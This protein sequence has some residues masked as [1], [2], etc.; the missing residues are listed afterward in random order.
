MF[1]RNPN[2][3]RLAASTQHQYTTEMFRAMKTYLGVDPTA[4]PQARALQRKLKT[5]SYLEMVKAPVHDLT[6][7]K[8]MFKQVSEDEKEFHL[9]LLA[10]MV[11]ARIG[12]LHH[13]YHVGMENA[14]WR[15]SWTNHKTFYR[16]GV[17]DVVIP[18]GCIPEEIIHLSAKPSGFVCSEEEKESIYCV[19]EEA[20]NGR[21]YTIRRS[22]LQHY[23]YNLG[24]SLEELRGISL[25]SDVKTLEAYL[26][27][28]TVEF[29]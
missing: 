16:R 22:A 6:S 10:F 1:I 21:T 18:R 7:I 24:M 13:L 5:Q 26:Q 4:Y 20:Y 25:H 29:E 19:M 2:R 9:M 17:I 11:A 15:L 12:S 23:R 14:G 28:K 3:P 8:S 27:S